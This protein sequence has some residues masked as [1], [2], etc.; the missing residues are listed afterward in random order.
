MPLLVGAVLALGAHGLGAQGATATGVPAGSAPATNPAAVT[1]PAATAVTSPAATVT[2]AVSSAA[3]AAAA[4]PAVRS[5]AATTGARQTAA[6]AAAAYAVRAGWQT[7]IAIVDLRTGQI[8]TAG[9]ATTHFPAESTIKLL[10]AAHLLAAGEMT[11]DVAA[12]AHAMVVASDDDAA[13]ALYE[14]AG[15]DG[16]G[17]WAAAR[18][19]VPAL[20]ALAGPV[21]GPGQWGSLPVSA[22]GMAQFLAAAADDPA[23]GPWLTATMAQLEPIAADGTDQRFGIKAAAPEAA[24]KQGWGGDVPGLDAEG[25]PSIG[26]VDGRYAVA[27]YTLH[28]PAVDQAGA[29]AMVTAQARL[30]LPGGHVPAL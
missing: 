3:A 2:A 20:A 30:L 17:A 13:N 9:A 8:T 23:V 7:G 28:A 27:I 14:L 16:V 29:Q 5:A 1:S 18:Y 6:D 19:G 22:L 15:G 24:V 12:A 4:A 26:Y 10:L 21:N 25:T 11:G